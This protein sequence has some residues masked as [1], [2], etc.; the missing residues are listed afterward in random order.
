MIHQYKNNGYNIVLDVNS[1]SVHV[2]DDV[3]YD[4][5][6]MYEEKGEKEITEIICG[7]YSDEGITEEELEELFDDLEQLKKEGT[8]FTEDTY[9]E[10]VI[11]FKQRQTVV[12]ALCIILPMPATSPADIVLPA[13]GSIRETVP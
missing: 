13:R 10:G 5:I 6:G 2:V 11:D 12:K 3:A 4:V 7:K 8:L 1:G 9:K